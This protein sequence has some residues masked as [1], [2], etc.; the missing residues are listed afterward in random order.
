MTMSCAFSSISIGTYLHRHQHVT[1]TSIMKL[2]LG[3]TWTETHVSSIF[4]NILP[5]ARR[6]F[7]SSPLN[8]NAYPNHTKL[9][10]CEKISFTKVKL[11]TLVTF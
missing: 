9:Y 5:T 3:L 2:V 6:L 7:V 4:L 11:R 10:F 1:H 8:Y